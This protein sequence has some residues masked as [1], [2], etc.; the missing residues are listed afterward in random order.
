MVMNTIFI[1]GASSGIGRATVKHF[2]ERG[3]N[4]V[5]NDAFT[6]PPK[7]QRIPVHIS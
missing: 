5:A 1:T 2:A 3:W 7:R 4:V 6:T